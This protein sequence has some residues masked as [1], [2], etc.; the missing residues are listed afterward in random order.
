[1][2]DEAKTIPIDLTSATVAARRAMPGGEVLMQLDCVITPPNN[3]DV[4][5]FHTLWADEF[6]ML[7]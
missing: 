1:V 2:A 7:S 3:I 6:I 5:L 4:R